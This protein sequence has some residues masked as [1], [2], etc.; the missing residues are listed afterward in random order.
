MKNKSQIFAVAFC[1]FVSLPGCSDSPSSSAS[2]AK[3]S[4]EESKPEAKPEDATGWRYTEKV[5]EMD[6]TKKTLATLVAD[7]TLDF[8]F[9]YGQSEFALHIRSWK[10]STDIY[11]V[12]SK[13]QFIAG[14]MGEKTYRVKFDDEAPMKISANHTTS[15]SSDV[16]FLGSESKLISKLKT[17]N[18]LIIE[19]E[20]F[21]AGYKRITFTTKGL[22]WQSL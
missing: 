9:P 10:G 16:V 12:C 15:G 13:C 6:G 18:K 20:F 3:P 19:A 11:L 17:A 8:D 7:N 14:I 1:I 4:K 21:D 2:S 5:D 22:Q